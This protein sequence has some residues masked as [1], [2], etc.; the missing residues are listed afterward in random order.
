M[1]LQDR[2]YTHA[3]PDHGGSLPEEPPNWDS[4]WIDLGGEG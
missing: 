4:I 1:G 2:Y 3:A